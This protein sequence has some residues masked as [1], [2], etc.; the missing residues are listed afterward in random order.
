MNKLRI[1]KQKIDRIAYL[2]MTGHS[3]LIYLDE[4]IIKLLNENN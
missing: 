4:P 2:N 1:A 3:I